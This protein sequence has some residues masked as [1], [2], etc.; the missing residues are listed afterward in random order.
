MRA[1]TLA[2]VLVRVMAHDDDSPALLAMLDD[3]EAAPIVDEADITR[4]VDMAHRTSIRSVLSDTLSPSQHIALREHAHGSR[5]TKE[6]ASKMGCSQGTAVEHLVRARAR[7]GAVS[8]GHA[9]ALA[10]GMGLFEPPARH[11]T[12]G[13][14]IARSLLRPRVRER[15][16]LE[17]LAKGESNAEIAA[18]LQ[19][20]VETV[21]DHIEDL[22][23][24][25]GARNRTHLVAL[26]FAVGTLKFVSSR[27][28]ATVSA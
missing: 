11:A 13:R 22:R 27:H 6:L 25:Y 2:D 10:L 16:L 28:R 23:E 7:L 20:T 3:L 21:K 9:V 8:N 4:L 24:L 5:S 26:A 1:S 14:F 18:G 19:L 15:D 17:R 12:E